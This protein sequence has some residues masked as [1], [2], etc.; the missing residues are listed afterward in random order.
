MEQNSIFRTWGSCGLIQNL[1]VMT[2]ERQHVF[3]SAGTI[4]VAPE[5]SKC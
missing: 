1:Q 2:G 4:C 3:Q 5:M